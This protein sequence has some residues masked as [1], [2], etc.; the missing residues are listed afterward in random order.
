MPPW[1]CRRVRE[2]EELLARARTD[3]DI[4]AVLLFG[5]AARGEPFR[6]IDVALVAAPDRGVDLFDL[7]MRYLSEV[8]DRVDVQ[9]YQS[10]P[11]HVRTRVLR[12]ARILHALDED[13][14]Y[15]LAFADARAWERFRPFYEEYLE[16]AGLA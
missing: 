5:S 10:L 4:A 7:R 1:A 8:G 13:A 15:A 11:L 14:L 3:R 9:V 12:D 2:L 16:G 6:D